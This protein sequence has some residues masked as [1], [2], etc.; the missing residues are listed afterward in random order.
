MF[1]SFYVHGLV[2]FAR[3]LIDGTIGM[4]SP[5]EISGDRLKTKAVSYSASTS[6]ASDTSVLR[7][8]AYSIL[9]AK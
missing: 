6:V 8:S 2:F 3:E 1:D 4:L 5:D 9:I 7:I